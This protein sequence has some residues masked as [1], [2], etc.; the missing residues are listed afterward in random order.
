MLED[1]VHDAA[2]TLWRKAADLDPDN[3][4]CAYFARC[5][6]NELLGRLKD[7]PR[8]RGVGG[9]A[10]DDLLQALPELPRESV[11]TPVSYALRQLLAGL[12]PLEREVLTVSGAS[13]FSLSGEEVARLL[14]STRDTV[15]S[16]RNRTKKRLKA[17]LEQWREELA[18]A[19]L[20]G[21]VDLREAAE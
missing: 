14:G 6:R 8:D 17:F 5:A 4:L 21:D 13:N 9:E 19:G 18:R 7:R 16:L 12:P 15:Y 1:A 20:D 11:E 3:N 2:L 10:S